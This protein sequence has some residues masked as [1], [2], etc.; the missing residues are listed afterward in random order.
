[1]RIV[2]FSDRF[3]R[4]PLALICHCSPPLVVPA[5]QGVGRLSERLPNLYQRLEAVGA[6]GAVFCQSP[7]N[8]SASQERLMVSVE[9]I[10]K[11]RHDAARKP[12]FVADPLQELS[13]GRPGHFLYQKR[14]LKK[15]CLHAGLYAPAVLP[16]TISGSK[17]VNLWTIVLT[18]IL[19]RART[20][21]E[22]T[23]V[24]ATEGHIFHF[25]ICGKPQVH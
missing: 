9:V 3:I 2:G 16:G 19:S 17:D 4:L 14:I 20:V 23:A 12:L 25:G 1:M 18:I 13:L 15:Q 24:S 10:G 5:F 21:N 6:H 11:E 22:R 8:G 7:Q